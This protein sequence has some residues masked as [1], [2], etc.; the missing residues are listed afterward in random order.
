M[1]QRLVLQDKEGQIIRSMVWEND[2]AVLIRRLDTKRIQLVEDLTP[3]EE[4]QIPVEKIADISVNEVKKSPYIVGELGRLSFYEESLETQENVKMN[5]ENQKSWWLSLLF[6]VALGVSLVGYMLG[7]KDQAVEEEKEEEKR[8][9]KIVKPEKQRVVRASQSFSK[10]R[11]PKVP[12]KV[13]KRSV[14]R[15]GALAVLGKLSKGKQ[16]AGLNLGAAK[17]SRGP[18]LGGGTA[19][20]GGVQ[21]NLYGKGIVAAP[22]G[23]GGNIKGAGGYGTKGKGGGQDG[24]GDLSLVGSS[25]TSSIPV[26]REAVVQGGLDRDLIDAVIRKN[27]GQIRYC[28]EQGLQGSPSLRGRVA[29]TFVI[30]AQGRVTSSS[31]ASSTMKSAQVEG[32]ILRRLSSWKFPLPEGGVSVKVTYPFVLRRLGKG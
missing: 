23:V 31:I 4:R 2:Q 22:V 20:S 1:N 14:K 5:E 27:M 26:G 15:M 21:T 24:Y 7:V 3:F 6:I 17:T 28:Y 10:F 18:G 30:G 12:T 16:R 8:V 11:K 32:C 9:V 19:G 29:V 25:G 13:V